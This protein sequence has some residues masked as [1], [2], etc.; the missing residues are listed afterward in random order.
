M[1]NKN[2]KIDLAAELNLTYLQAD[3]ERILFNERLATEMLL[4]Y[5]H[6]VTTGRIK[7]SEKQ[8][9]DLLEDINTVKKYGSY[10]YSKEKSILAELNK[11]SMF[12]KELFKLPEAEQYSYFNKILNDEEFF[13]V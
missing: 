8:K 9:Q 5:L 11:K 10:D 2:I 13:K 3:Y 7:L 1:S 6:K 12:Y 4:S